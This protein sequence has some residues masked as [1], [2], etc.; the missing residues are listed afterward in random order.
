MRA[1]VCSIPAR[2]GRSG[3]RQ[4]PGQDPPAGRAAVRGRTSPTALAG[5]VGHDLVLAVAVEVGEPHVVARQPPANGGM[6]VAVS[7][8]K[9]PLPSPRKTQVV[10][11]AGQRHQVELAVAVEVAV[12]RAR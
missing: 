11:V 10:A 8:V 7:R 6:P 1:F 12:G 3:R 4:V 9:Q 5:E 2:G